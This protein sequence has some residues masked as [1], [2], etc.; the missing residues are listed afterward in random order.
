MPASNR[1]QTQRPRLIE[2]MI[3]SAYRYGYAGANI[4]RVIESAGVSRPTFYE[5]FANKDDCFLAAQREVGELLVREVQSAVAACAPERAIHAALQ[6]FV[7]LAEVHPDRAGLLVSESMAGGPRSLDEHDRLID[8]LSATIDAARAR[9]PAAT[10]TP[11]LPAYTVLGAGRWLLAPALRKGE[12]DLSE[13]RDDMIDWVD[14]YSRPRAAHRW[15]QLDPHS[16]PELKPT[17]SFSPLLSKPP[18]PT[19]P[20]RPRLADKEITRNQRER[21]MYATALML[22]EHGYNALT[23]AHISESAGI[24]RRVFYTHFRNKEQAFVALHELAMRQTLANAAHAFFSVPEWPDRV[25]EAMRATTQF[26]GAH[27]I[28]AHFGYIESH[29][30]GTPAIQRIDDARA[31]FTIFLQEGAQYTER[32]PSRTAMEAIGGAVFE[33]GYRITRLQRVNLLSRLAPHA[34]YIVLAPFLGPANTDKLI[35]SK[36]S[37]EAISS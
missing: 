22:A 25:W 8:R 10:L 2:G 16:F 33:I 9:V 20:G 7:E 35:D 26:E 12:R 24:D 32:P 18:E 34:S 15:N 31:A 14:S 27:P 13:L 11:D 4:S 21:I 37:K 28:V 5:Y 29:A 6:R 30:V 1:K 36:L 19:T 3:A 17:I 23:V